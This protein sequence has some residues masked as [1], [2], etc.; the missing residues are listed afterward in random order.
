M[1]KKN[2]IILLM[3]PFIIALLSIVTANITISFIDKDILGIVWEYG[4]TE[5]YKHIPG[6]YYELKAQALTENNSTLGE[7]NLLEWVVQNKDSSVTEPLAEIVSRDNRYFLITKGFGEVIVTCRN[8]NGNVSRSFTALIY[9]SG[10]VVAYPVISSS[11]ANI[12]ETVYY[13]THDI[14]NNQKVNA[15]IALKVVAAPEHLYNDIVYYDLSDNIEIDPSTHTVKVK[16]SGEAYFTVS[17]AADE[18]ITPYTYRFYIVEDG[19]NVYTYDDL[20]YCTNKSEQGEIVVLRKSFE[21]IDNA[22]N[23]NGELIANNV[24]IFGHYTKRGNDYNFSFELSKGELWDFETTYNQNFIQEWNAFARSDS[25]YQEITNRVNVGLRVQKDFYGNGFTINMHNLAFPYEL[26]EVSTDSGTVTIP[27]LTADNKFRGPLPFYTLGD[28]NKL[29]LVTAYGQD[30]VGMYVDGDNITINDLELKNC[31]FGNSLSN[32]EYT[33]TVMELNGDNILIKNSRLLN[34]KNV[35][36]SFSNDNVTIY[37]SMLSYAMN[38]LISTGSNKFIPIDGELNKAFINSDGTKGDQKINVFLKK[39]A[40]GDKILNSFIS[41]GFTDKELMRQSVIAMQEALNNESLVEGQFDGSMVV[42]DTLFYKSGIASI[43]LDSYFNGPFLYSAIP[44]TISSLLGMF[45]DAESGVKLIPIIPE[46]IS[47]LSYPVKLSLEGSTK[48][49]DQKSIYDI[50]LNGLINENMS[51]IASGTGML[52]EDKLITID[53]IFPVKS[54]LT[55]LGKNNIKQVSDSSGNTKHYISIPVVKYGGGGNLSVYDASKLDYNKIDDLSLSF[56]DSYLSL[57]DGG[58]N[59]IAQMQNMILKTVTTVTGY[60][61]FVF[62]CTEAGYL[63]GEAPNISELKE[64]LKED[65][66]WKRRLWLP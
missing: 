51:E 18:G 62:C 60:E 4:E 34:G 28:P 17:S 54:L 55:S 61:P 30:N 48:F 66:K 22:I 49:Y 10:A 50:D 59:F 57:G 63:Y 42:K 38:F 12:D 29:P 32:L 19:V 9:E 23:S 26:Q 15:K 44:S 39:D 40:E 7:G 6:K 2:L 25:R 64:N 24:D 11:G 35:L 21:S 65:S 13:G 46:E 8:I 41:A 36:R 31:D 52:E 20:L 27:V 5:T 37:N 3:I 58:G 56:L 43:S 14:E 16:G 45:E 53:H 47:G 1:G 33:G